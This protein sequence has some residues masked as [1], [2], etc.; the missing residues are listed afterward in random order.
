MGKLEKLSVV[1][2]VGP[3]EEAWRELLTDLAVLPSHAEII[4]SGATLEPKDFRSV[5]R[6]AGLVQ[7]VKWFKSPKGRAKQLNVGAYKAH[8]DFLWFVHADS[9]ISHAT[10]QSLKKSLAKNENAI[11]FFNLLFLSDG[12]ALTRI[13]SIGVWIRSRLLRLPFGDQGLCVPKAVFGM[14][15]GFDEEA[16]YG[17]DHLFIWHAKRKRIPLVCTGG[18]LFTSARKY[19]KEGWGTTTTHHALLTAKQAIPE[20]FYL[21]K[22]RTFL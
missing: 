20:L 14:L 2:P 16:A 22:E 10:I 1:I 15:G 5:V 7:N 4:I 12:P 3:R 18:W 8:G 6:S 19:R 21:L 11:H 9:R 17:E 13:N